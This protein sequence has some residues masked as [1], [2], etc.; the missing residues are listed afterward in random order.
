MSSNYLEMIASLETLVR[1]VADEEIVPR[2][3][4]GK[5]GKQ[6]KLDGSVLTEVDK[7]VQDRIEQGLQQRWPDIA[8]L[9]E[10]MS[11]EQQQQTMQSKAVWCLDPLDGTSNFASGI[12][13]FGVSLALIESQQSILGLV[14]D[15]IRKECFTAVKGEGCWLNGV[16]LSDVKNEIDLST[17]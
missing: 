8:F 4:S 14:Y 2:F 12:P 17:K 11:G 5:F 10:E 1:Q 13:F 7:N 15:P 9:G 6:T 3:T 16:K